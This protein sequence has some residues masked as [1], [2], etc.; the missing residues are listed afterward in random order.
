MITAQAPLSFE[1]ELA[2]WLKTILISESSFE[3]Q[4]FPDVNDSFDGET[5]RGIE[6]AS[7]VRSIASALSAVVC[8]SVTCEYACA[9]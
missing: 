4:L 2:I 7:R 6:R 1:R 5:S 3:N 8:H 9:S